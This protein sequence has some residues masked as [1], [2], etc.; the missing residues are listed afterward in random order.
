M[1]LLL[2]ILGVAFLLMIAFVVVIALTIRSKLKGFVKVFE[3]FSTVL[4]TPSRITLV[5]LAAPSWE[6]PEANAAVEETLK[7]L[8]F[9]K[10]GNYQVEEMK[11]LELEGWQ[12]PSQS[13]NAVIYERPDQGNWIDFYTHFED[14]TRITYTNSSI[15]AGLDPAPGHEMGRFP[16]MEVRE[17]FEKFVAGRPNKPAKTISRESFASVLEVVYAKEMEWRNSRGGATLEEIRAIGASTGEVYDDDAIEATHE[18]AERQAMEEL[19]ET[20][21]ERFLEETKLSAIEWERVRDR[22]I[23]IHDSMNPDA[24]EEAVGA[25]LDDDE[26]ERLD[27]ESDALPRV[28]FSDFNKTLAEARRF[29]RLGTVASPVGAD[30]YAVPEN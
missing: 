7:S 28:A 18:L 24:F 22:V 23:V 1:G 4:G 11:G 15:G 6:N 16:G 9:V 10:A 19:D 12:I 27:F 26:L 2:Q 3:G 13:I 5:P 29:K 17:L 14:G 30:I 21:R 20:I 25:R 8:G